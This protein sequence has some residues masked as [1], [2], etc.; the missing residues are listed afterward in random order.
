MKIKIDD[1]LTYEMPSIAEYIPFSWGQEIV[2]W[3]IARRVNRKMRRYNKRIER[4]N[5]IKRMNDK[6]L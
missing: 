6:T 3:Y 4:E 1:L 5:F 2:A